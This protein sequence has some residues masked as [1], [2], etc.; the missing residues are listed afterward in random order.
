MLDQKVLQYGKKTQT[1]HVYVV[2]HWK[3]FAFT[4]VGNFADKSRKKLWSSV[5]DHI[6]YDTCS[7]ECKTLVKAI[8]ELRWARKTQ[9]DVMIFPRNL[10]T[11][12]AIILWSQGQ[13][14]I[15]EATTSS[16]YSENS[17][18]QYYSA[19]S[20]FYRLPGCFRDDWNSAWHHLIPKNNSPR[21]NA[22]YANFKCENTPQKSHPLD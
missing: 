7:S 16:N 18:K 6:P 1:I 21:Y 11:Q 9:P 5:T 15:K 3:Q 20:E 10:V 12:F 17:D 13:L 4:D 8:S 19:N 22:E 14:V 2:I